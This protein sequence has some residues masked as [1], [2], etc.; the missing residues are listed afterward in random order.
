ML[1]FAS[2]KMF[3]S[4]QL[5]SNMDAIG[6]GTFGSATTSLTLFELICRR[7]LKPGFY[8][9]WNV[10]RGGEGKLLAGDFFTLSS[11]SHP[12]VHTQRKFQSL[13]FIGRVLSPQAFCF[14]GCLKIVMPEVKSGRSQA[15]LALGFN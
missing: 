2:F 7:Y 1:S 14:E 4:D 12:S 15:S 13:S 11:K 3:K 8:Q 10:K 9:G 5:K 6:G